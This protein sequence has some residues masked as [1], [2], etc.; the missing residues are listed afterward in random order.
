MLSNWESV[1]KEMVVTHW[2]TLS[3]DKN[4]EG[5]ELIA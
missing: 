5:V 2:K 1:E 3:N 4:G